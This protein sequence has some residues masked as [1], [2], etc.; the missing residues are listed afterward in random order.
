MEHKTRPEV[1]SPLPAPAAPSQ[2]PNFVPASA[3]PAGSWTQLESRPL[4]RPGTISRSA[5]GPVSTPSPGATFDQATRTGAGPLPHQKQMEGAFGQDFSN[6]KSHVGQAGAL[7]P[8]GARAATR[9]ET[10]SFAETSPG[11]R[12]VAH[13]LA[14]VVQHRQ[15]GGGG[16]Q[17]SEGVSDPSSAAEREAEGVADQVMAGAR[18]QVRQA[19]SAEIQPTLWSDVNGKFTQLGQSATTLEKLGVVFTEVLKCNNFAEFQELVTNIGAEMAKATLLK[20]DEAA[21]NDS[22]HAVLLARAM[23]AAGGMK[24]AVQNF[25]AVTPK[26]VALLDA[27]VTANLHG[28][29]LDTTFVDSNLTPITNSYTAGVA[30]TANQRKVLSHAIEQTTN[31][32]KAKSFFSVRFNIPTQDLGALPKDEA[33]ATEGEKVK[34]PK[35]WDLAG[36]K[37]AYRVMNTLP[38]GHVADNAKFKK[39][40]RF[41]DGTSGWH[42]STTDT[43]AIGY[44]DGQLSDNF[45]DNRT[46]YERNI[47]GKAPEVFAGKNIFDQT[48]R[49][50]VGHAVDAKLGNAGG[51]ASYCIANADGGSWT[52]YLALD[53]FVAGVIDAAG[54]QMKTKN[55]HTN[56]RF[57]ALISMQWPP[58]NVQ[59]LK[60]AV[61]GALMDDRCGWVG[62]NALS[63]QV[64]F[65]ILDGEA[66]FK[67]ASVDLSAPWKTSGGLDFGGRTFVKSSAT[68]YYSYATAARSKQVSNY[69]FRSPMEWFAEAYAAYYSP[70]GGTPAPYGDRLKAKDKTTFDHMHDNVDKTLP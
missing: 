70:N 42:N 12:V 52:K 1:F 34:N 49:H 51:S 37:Q 57:L 24:A 60:Q 13:E 18:V 40:L 69:Q 3:R 50:E 68:D 64:R 25:L 65:G 9:G 26:A 38:D 36:L 44:Q 48:I 21:Q 15:S 2:A 41:A 23:A 6:V 61:D 27:L 8:L 10:I 62:W 58:D 31:L 47:S 28:Q 30:T 55:L 16:I 20:F 4:A 59:A 22:D 17:T 7:A 43:M 45:A 29:I 67:I 66:F 53:E 32:V 33:T 56:V 35:D 54:G 5:A 39:L 46:F 14:H 19:P 11:P 63:D